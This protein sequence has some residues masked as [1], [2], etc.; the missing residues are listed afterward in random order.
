MGNRIIV[1]GLNGDYIYAV[2][3]KREEVSNLLLADMKKHSNLILASV[4]GDY[5]DNV[6]SMFTCAVFIRVPEDIRMK[7]VKDR[8]L[9]KFGNRMLPGGDLYEKEMR[10]FDMVEHRLEQDVE[11][12]I[13]ANRIPTVYVDGTRSNVY[14]TEFVIRLLNDCYRID[15]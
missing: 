8:S 13:K 7:R 1:C 10:F 9:Q 12:W 14:N 4:K 11:D 15:G 5:G 6:I 2:T 3:H